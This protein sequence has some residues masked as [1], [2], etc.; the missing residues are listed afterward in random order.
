MPVQAVRGAIQLAADSPEAM[1]EGVGRLLSR[2]LEANGFAE[3]NI[4]SI[5]FSQT[6]D[7]SAENPA[8]A[9]RRSGFAQTPLFCTSEPSYPDSL[10][11]VLRVLVTVEVA[12]RFEVRPVYLDGAR[13]L[14]P[15]IPEPG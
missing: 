3:D 5:L 11:R 10:P 2:M 15:D 6:T 14:R 9:L 12:E 8:R 13:R 7:L 1:T 4:V